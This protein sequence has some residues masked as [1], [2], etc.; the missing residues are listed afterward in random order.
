LG[1]E[2]NC[3]FCNPSE[4]EMVLASDQCFARWDKYPVTKGHLLIILNR[5]V[6]DYFAVTLEEKTALWAM[7]DE[8]KKLLD[9]RFKPDGYN[10]GINVGVAAGQTVMHCHIHLIPRRSG[11]SA[12]P[13]GGVRGVIP[14]RADYAEDSRVVKV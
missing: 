6:A 1:E 9:E 11:D 10:V 4:R 12:N 5:H 14:G 7:V 3:P 8:G 13:R 2:L